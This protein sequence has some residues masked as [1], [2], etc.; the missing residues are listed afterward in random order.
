[1]EKSYLYSRIYQLA[2]DFRS[3]NDFKSIDGDIFILSALDACFD[4]MDSRD[5][6]DEKAALENVFRST[7][8]NVDLLYKMLR[9]RIL[10]RDRN[11][12][13]YGQF[14][15]RTVYN[16][17]NAIAASGGK[18]L[19][20]DEV[21]KSLLRNPMLSLKETLAV[22][23]APST[24]D[25]RPL[26]AA[27][28]S[29]EAKPI[30]GLFGDLFGD[31]DKSDDESAPEER[32]PES[33]EKETL[34]QLVKR[35]KE[36]QKYALDIVFGQDHAINSFIEG[37]FQAQ[38][39]AMTQKNSV[40]PKAMFLF[41]GPPGVG[42]T[43][44]A[45]QTAD[46]LK[47]P[48]KRFN[49]SE[50]AGYETV[51]QFIGAEPTYKAAKE[52]NVTGFVAKNPQCILLFD[53]IEKAHLNIIQLFLQMLDAGILRDAFTNEDVFF[54]D[55]III[56]TTNAGKQI[57]DDPDIVNLATV[58]RK[59]ILSALQTEKRPD[60][61]SPF[62]P[63]AICSRFAAG[64]VIMFNRLGAND[65]LKI[66][67]SEL[68][69]FTSSF[70]EETG[71]E[72]NVDRNVLYALLFSEG[73]KVDARTIRGRAGTFF[74]QESYELLRLMSSEQRPYDIDKLKNI[75]IKVQ[76]PDDPKLSKLFEEPTAPNVLVFASEKLAEK[77]KKSKQ[78]V[79]FIFADDMETAKNIVFD[80]D[81]SLIL[82][83]VRCGLEDEAYGVLNIEDVNTVGSE[84]IRYAVDNL[85]IPA[86]VFSENKG[87][88]SAEEMQSFIAKG[89][90]GYVCL[91][92]ESGADFSERVYSLCNDAEQQKK[93]LEFVRSNKVLRYSTSQVVSEGSKSATIYL[94]DFKLE[95]APDAD[96]A[97][98]LLNS[99]YKPD[100]KFA[101]VIG[102]NDA[103]EELQFFIKYLSNPAEFARHGVRM[104]KGVLLYGPPG[105][106][107]TLLAKAMAGESDA[108]FIAT[109]GNAFIKTF[110]GQGPEAMHDIF[111]VARKYAPSILFIDEMDVFARSRNG[112]GDANS[113]ASEDVLTAFLSEMDGFKTHPDKP[114]FVLAATNYGVDGKG[115]SI[116][117]AIVRRFDRTIYVDLPNKEERAKFMRMQV[118]KH[119]NF[120]LGEQEIEAIAT[121]TTGMSLADLESV[122]ELALRNAIRA[123]NFTVDEEA[124]D[125]AFQSFTSGEKKTVYSQ[126]ELKKTA[127]HEAGHTLVY[128]LNGIVPS[129]VTIVG[130]GDYGGYMRIGDEE[131][132]GCETRDELLGRMR[133]SLAG[134]AAELEYYGEKD[135]LTTGASSDLQHATNVARYLIGYFGMDKWLYSENPDRAD[136]SFA[137]A[138]RERA[139]ELLKQELLNARKIIADNKAAIDA[140]VDALL[141]KD[142]LG[143][144]E[145]D[146]ILKKHVVK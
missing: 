45:E 43:F 122:I 30:K 82:C 127:R 47:L 92:D 64:N 24:G 124:F 91:N 8:L 28:P 143:G 88:I 142:H 130:R 54:K 50:Y 19:T 22:I 102:A 78:T 101:D 105:T 95:V 16:V 5:D 68:N 114:V 4:N 120:A 89:V 141:E 115:N 119:K 106:G 73:A 21:V 31:I 75:D 57:Y 137:A 103:K 77:V 27:A 49:M 136:A 46:F 13:L 74:G 35:V 87:D 100:K 146:A 7:T 76:I 65:L 34:A 62:F 111:K 1:M 67:E 18:L 37:Y 133:V 117:R 9:G 99:V 93:L 40:K 58:S 39:I 113:K 121:R 17:S 69:K 51:S 126:E 33:P 38:I 26:N 55:T 15:T 79:N 44:L 116:D 123:D 94:F 90:R 12:S 6:H 83:D 25:T 66:A 3:K 96:D 144:A 60:S 110:V 84:F 98:D 132:K 71:I 63:A 56:F 139:D 112:A 128:W 29:A 125:E 129:Y 138:V 81:I 85:S 42:K 32:K 61:D 107:K 134:R 72:V 2:D 118:K 10:A 108:S 104:P 41:A 48:F 97:K 131:E 52:G 80:K 11:N 109:E 53:E 36:G 86:Y 70:K 135:G 59:Q 140:L 14:F 23:N 145:I 20:A